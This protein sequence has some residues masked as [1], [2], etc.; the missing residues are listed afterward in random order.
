MLQV[1]NG[2]TTS[3][4]AEKC[5]PKIKTSQSA[6][7]ILLGIGNI[8]SNLVFKGKRS[9][10]QLPMGDYSI[11][12]IVK[13]RENDID[14][15]TFIQIVKFEE[16]KK[17]RKAELSNINWLGNVS[18]GDM[19]LIQFD[20]ESYGKSSYLLEFPCLE[21]EY[22]VRVRNP[23]EQYEKIILFYCF[24]IHAPGSK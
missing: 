23:N 6:G 13:C 9:T 7:Q 14:P 19:T 17:E 3:V 20:A 16:T 11:K 8:R 2:D 15:S 18:R 21:G 10:T 24:G 1:D 22:G 5:V 12:L 4:A